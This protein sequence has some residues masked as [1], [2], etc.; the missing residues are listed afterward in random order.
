MPRRRSNKQLAAME[1]SMD[2]MAL[3]DAG[4]NYVYLNRSHADI[5]GY[6]VD[7]LIG[8]TWRVLL[9][10]EEVSR[11]ESNE[12]PILREKGQWQGECVGNKK[13]GSRFPREI[14]L[15]MMKDGGVACI[16]RDVSERKS[17]EQQKADLFAMVSHD[18]KSPPTAILGYADTLLHETPPDRESYQMRVS[19]RHSCRK[20]NGIMRDFLTLSHL[21]SVKSSLKESVCRPGSPGPGDGE[22]LCDAGPGQEITI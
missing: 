1:A 21:E 15:V 20:I 8:K 11:I 7:E 13:D 18:I 2:G 10:A 5:Y 14:S 9:P 3:L 12:F 19:I 22:G 6:T 4:G 16:A 17:L